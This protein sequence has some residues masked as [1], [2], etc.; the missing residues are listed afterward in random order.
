MS[1]KQ[2]GWRYIDVPVRV[3]A[4]DC[5]AR[6][7]KGLTAVV[8][9]S[10]AVDRLGIDTGDYYPIWNHVPGEF[11]IVPVEGTPTPEEPV[12]YLI[13]VRRD[14][15]TIHVIGAS[16]F[17]YVGVQPCTEFDVKRGAGG[18][19]FTPVGKGKGGGK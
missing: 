12:R 11:G 18:Y 6:A 10:H 9:Y 17:R 19:V 16:F 15:N 3:K 1:I 2:T 7:H 8:I 14:R 13:R 4:R 5:D